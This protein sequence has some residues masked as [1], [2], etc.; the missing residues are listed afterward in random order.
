M[1]TVSSIFRNEATMELFLHPFLGTIEASL[2]YL[3]VLRG[4]GIHQAGARGVAQSMGIG[5]YQIGDARLRY[6]V[7]SLV[8]ES[9]R[10]LTLSG[11]VFDIDDLQGLDST[12]WSSPSSIRQLTR[13]KSADLST[14]NLRSCTLKQAI[15]DDTLRLPLLSTLTLTSLVFDHDRVPPNFLSPEC[16]PSLSTLSL[17]ISSDCIVAITPAITSIASQI[18]ALSVDSQ[19]LFALLH[20]PATNFL[21]GF[22]NLAYID[23]HQ[24]SGVAAIVILTKIISPLRYLRFSIRDYSS[25]KYPAAVTRLQ[26]YFELDENE[27]LRTLKSMSFPERAR[28]DAELREI[29][30]TVVRLLLTPVEYHSMEEG[31]LDWCEAMRRRERAVGRVEEG[32]VQEAS[33][34]TA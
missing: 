25:W 28:D 3:D 32:K 18:I 6:I 22:V 13:S 24:V 11:V 16:L 8:I 1:A 4:K 27:Y 15:D 30:T 5:S 21:A 33:L 2:E 34:T 9:L 7:R 12:S 29:K 31:F 23:L 14:L 20:G 19:A 17:Q 26:H 10:S